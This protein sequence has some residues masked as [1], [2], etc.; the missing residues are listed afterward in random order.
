MRDLLSRIKFQC[1]RPVRIFDEIGGVI[2]A[3]QRMGRR[4]SIF[5]ELIL[6]NEVERVAKLI[7][8]GRPYGYR[9]NVLSLEGKAI[10][11]CGHFVLLYL[12]EHPG[13]H[14]ALDGKRISPKYGLYNTYMRMNFGLFSSRLYEEEIEMVKYLANDIE[15]ESAPGKSPSKKYPTTG[16]T[17]AMLDLGMNPPEP[18]EYLDD[19]EGKAID[20][21][22]TFHV[23]I[24][25]DKDIYFPKGDH[26]V[27]PFLTLAHLC[28]SAWL[29]E[30]VGNDKYRWVET[31]LVRYRDMLIEKSSAKKIPLDR[32]NEIE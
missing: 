19:R 14:V 22:G 16:I 20:Y 23:T 3:E 5:G 15:I 6:V 28:I 8:A 30:R 13:R 27:S 31:L 7:A 17:K 29:L 2:M 4:A 10:I 12:I 9:C 11:R 24:S 21:P 18:F 1:D 26:D 32:L 25:V